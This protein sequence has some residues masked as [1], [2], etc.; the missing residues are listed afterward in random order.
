MA[1][2]GPLGIEFYPWW[3]EYLAKQLSNWKLP[4]RS[5]SAKDGCRNHWN[6]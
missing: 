6:E 2:L 5:K 3:Q 1:N 4:R